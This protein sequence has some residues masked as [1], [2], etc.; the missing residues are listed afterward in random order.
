MAFD[1]PLTLISPILVGRTA[2]ATLEA[3]KQALAHA[4]GGTGRTVLL[5]GEAGI[6]KSRL[7]AEARALAQ[8]SFIV[9]EGHCFEP[10]GAIPYAPVLDL[11]RSR[12]AAL[13]AEELASEFGHSADG[14]APGAHSSLI[15]E[16]AKL[17]PEVTTP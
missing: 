16:M 3:L 15:T 7:V 9:L 17:L 8:D 13:S 2:A 12:F 10:D 6:G 14:H 5:A 4:A 11:L 1:R